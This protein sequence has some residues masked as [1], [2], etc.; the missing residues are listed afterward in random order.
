MKKL[1]VM[2]LTPLL[3][4]VAFFLTAAAETKGKDRLGVP[5]I[6]EARK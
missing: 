3:V 1:L 5:M 2:A 4:T 6:V